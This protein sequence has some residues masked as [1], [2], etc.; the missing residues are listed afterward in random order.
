MAYSK[1]CHHLADMF[2]GLA[3]QIDNKIMTY[4][5]IARQGTCEEY[6]FN[7]MATTY[8]SSEKDFSMFSHFVF[9][10]LTSALVVCFKPQIEVPLLKHNIC[11]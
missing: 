10:S 8:I 2:A 6:D 5:E 4:R 11:G 3:K 9:A 1:Q 7:F